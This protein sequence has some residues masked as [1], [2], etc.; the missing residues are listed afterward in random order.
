MKTLSTIFIAISVIFGA[1][2]LV[3]SCVGIGTPNWQTTYAILNG[4]TQP[5]RTA[6]FFYSCVFYPNGTRIGCTSRVSDRNIGQYYPIDARGNQT[7]WNQHLDNAAGLC[8]VG[9]IFIFFGTVATLLM[10]P[11]NWGLWIYWIGPTCYFLACLFML[12]GMS[13]GAYVLYY[14]DYAAN[15]YQTGHLLTI[16]SFAMSSVAAGHLYTLP[17][18]LNFEMPQREQYK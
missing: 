12:A 7:E 18:I 4:Q 16:F 14:N 13:E 15:L 9:I 17:E 6:N 2:A 1:I 8:I 3:L 11:A 5:V 10:L